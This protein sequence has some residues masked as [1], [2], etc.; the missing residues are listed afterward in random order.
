[1]QLCKK[2]V[3]VIVIIPF[4]VQNC[5]KHGKNKIKERESPFI[6][7]KCRFMGKLK[8]KN[9]FILQ[10]CKINDVYSLWLHLKCKNCKL[11]GKT[12]QIK[13]QTPFFFAKNAEKGVL[14]E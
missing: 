5:L 10:K 3:Y 13:V 14:G 2:N 12:K 7:Q 8:G 9:T 6:L 1:M 11:I 4:C